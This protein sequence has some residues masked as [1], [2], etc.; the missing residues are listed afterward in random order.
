[1]TKKRTYKTDTRKMLTQYLAE[2]PDRQFTAEELCIAVNGSCDRGKSSIY[3]HIS[4]LCDEGIL[5]KFR[6]EDDNRNVYQYVGELCD[7]GDHFH[8][9]CLRCGSLRHLDCADSILFAK[10]LLSEHGF[11]INCGQSILYGVCA[12]CRKKEGERLL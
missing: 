6:S 9:K 1:M 7:C 10:H 8:E 5:Q 11:S 12:E 4:A 2:H 3:R